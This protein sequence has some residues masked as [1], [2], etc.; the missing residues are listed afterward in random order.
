LSPQRVPA[1]LDPGERELSLTG[2]ALIELLQ[3]EDYGDIVYY[4]T[5]CLV[6]F[7]EQ[8]WDNPQIK[9]TVHP[10]PEPC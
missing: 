6:V 1:F 5:I 3:Y 4:F 10:H 7:G 9:G 8:Y 2:P